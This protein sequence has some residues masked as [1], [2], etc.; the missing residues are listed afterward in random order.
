LTNL[1]QPAEFDD[2]ER[3]IHWVFSHDRMRFVGYGTL[4]GRARGELGVGPEQGPFPGPVLPFGHNTLYSA[5]VA[6]QYDVEQQQV[7]PRIRLPRGEVFA[8]PPDAAGENLS[9]LSN[10]ALYFYPGREA[11][12]TLDPLEPLFRIPM[13][14]AVGQLGSIELIE[15]LEG[16]L[17]SFSFTNG[18]WSGEADPYQQVVRVD[19]EGGVRPVARRNLRHDLPIAYTTRL[20]WMSP[21]LRELSLASP[22]LFAA[23]RP[24]D[25]REIPTPPS[26]V[27]ILAGALGLLSMLAALRLTRRQ[28]H[29]PLARWG[30]VLACG[31]IGAPALV[32]LWLLFPPHRQIDDLRL[33]LPATA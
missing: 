25:E 11:A 4:D 18:A 27:V 9:V 5:S 29:T 31:V 15:L 14:G 12:N 24:L 21:V 13:P 2:P 22:R 23:P 3:S 8:S 17:V 16:Y 30:W 28:Q 33:A 10:R 6:Y 20:W 1:Q 7:F 26:A 32:S 19:G